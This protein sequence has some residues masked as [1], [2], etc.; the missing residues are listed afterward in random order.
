M[1][2]S[3]GFMKAA[4]IV[5]A[6]VAVHASADDRVVRWGGDA[7]GGAPFV[8]ADP[9]DPS[10]LRGFDVE[11]AGEIAKGLRRK[12]EFVQVAFSDI[13]QSV[14]RGDFDIGM[15]GV[16]DTPARRA[17]LAATIPYYEFHEVLTVRSEDAQRFTDFSK[18]RGRRVGTLSATIAYERLLRAEREDGIVAV[19]YDD[20]VHPYEDL[21]EG[22]LDAVLLDNIIAARS[23]KRVGGLHIQ[24]NSFATGHY[25]GV[26]A[27]SNAKL[28]DR[29]NEIL[30]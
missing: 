26:L 22:R 10:V 15:S 24:P 29:I 6:L 8:E 18:L 9:R 5:C 27:K 21:R 19:S 20:D 3:L 1:N 4:A 7:E 23:Q 2:S 25:V 17:M 12:P 11:V 16:E 13:D 30:K 28:R 14:R